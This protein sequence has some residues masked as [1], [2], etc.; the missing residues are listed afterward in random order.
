MRLVF[1]RAAERDLA[2]IEAFI[3]RDSISAA[4]RF[5]RRLLVACET[6]VDQPRAYA[7]AGVQDLRKRPMDDYLIFYRVSDR[8]EIVRI[9]HAARDWVRLLD[10]ADD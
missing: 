4:R 8:V 9:L 10:P 6:L 3:A 2:E 1:A 5:V 7:Q